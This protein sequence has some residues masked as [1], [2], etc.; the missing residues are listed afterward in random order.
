MVA[1]SGDTKN[2]GLAGAPS[3]AVVDDSPVVCDLLRMVLARAGW[4]VQTHQDAFGIE[5]S[6]SAF[7]P[8]LILLDVGMRGLEEGGLRERI[9]TLK[10]LTG[11]RLLL[12]SARD[13]EPLADLARRAGADGS[14]AKSG[15]ISHILSTLDTHLG[16]SRA[17][18][19]C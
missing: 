10:K 7:R 13:P 19:P 14:L 11:A 5:S 6:M 12:H 4:R 2:P 16:S 1:R 3:C 15:D 8:D 18:L 17:S 9:A